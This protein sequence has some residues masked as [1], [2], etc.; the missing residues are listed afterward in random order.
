MEAFEASLRGYKHKNL[1]FWLGMLKSIVKPIT[2]EHLILDYGCG[3]GLFL[4]LLYENYPY[5]K[6]IGFDRDK[7]SI[8]TAKTFLY[9]RHEDWPIKYFDNDSFIPEDFQGVFDY[10]F[11]Q[12]ILWMNNDIEKLANEIYS[13]LKPNG[14]C[15]C[16]IGS[17]DQNPL[18]NFRKEK[19]EKEGMVTNTWNINEIAKIFSASGFAVGMRRLP[20]DGFIMYHP[21]FTEEHS[22]SFYELVKT[23]YENKMLFYFGKG[24]NVIK[25]KTLQG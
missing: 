9:E 14:C 6:G 19:M 7:N 4:Q 10:I 18:W 11:C 12:E 1:I 8:D 22:N 5:K 13:L 23:S 20:I 21:E 17:H 15:Y 24:D 3:Q 2:K 25:P 16:T